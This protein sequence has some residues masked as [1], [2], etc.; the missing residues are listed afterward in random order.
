MVIQTELKLKLTR[1]DVAG[2]NDIQ[3]EDATRSEIHFERVFSNFTNV[4]AGISS[5]DY[6]PNIH[7]F[8]QT[9]PIA[10]NYWPIASRA[11]ISDTDKSDGKELTVFGDRPHGGGS[12]SVGSLEIMVQRRINNSA[13]QD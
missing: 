13:E 4:R 12:L 9:D 1:L 6:R 11:R 5:I 8:E 3:G 10:G 2:F 7:N